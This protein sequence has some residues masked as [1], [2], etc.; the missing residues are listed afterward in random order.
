MLG[1]IFKLF[2]IELIL[3]SNSFSN[4]FE[5]NGSRLIGLYDE[6]ISGGLPGLGMTIMVE[7]F[8]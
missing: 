3:L 7:N 1:I 5:K 2:M 4:T 8:H 6:V